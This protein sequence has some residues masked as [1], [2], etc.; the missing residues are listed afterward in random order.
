LIIEHGGDV[1]ANRWRNEA[2]AFART[3]Q[4]GFDLMTQLNMLQQ[5]RDFQVQMYD[6]RQGDITT[7]EKNRRAYEEKVREDEAL[8][9][10]RRDAFKYG[11][12]RLLAQMRDKK[13][14]ARWEAQKRFTLGL[15][16][17]DR[18][19][20]D[21]R[22]RAQ[23]HYDRTYGNR[24]KSLEYQRNLLMKANRMGVVT[25]EAKVKANIINAEIEAIRLQGDRF[26][27]GELR[28]EYKPVGYSDPINSGYR[29]LK[30]QSKL[31]SKTETAEDIWR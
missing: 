9:T 3:T 13:A 22:L 17:Q 4:Q 24:I 11:R 8:E 15:R 10:Q 21:A 2:S 29:A 19:L 6:K 28:Y 23:T 18:N 25:N 5:A 26:L 27:S 12:D 31:D 1:M 7:R 30:A 14:Q 20:S 16:R